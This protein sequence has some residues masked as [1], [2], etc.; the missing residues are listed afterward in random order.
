LAADMLPTWLVH[1]DASEK[2]VCNWHLC[3]I[4]IMSVSCY[5]L[6]YNFKR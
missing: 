1:C 6:T 3:C 2:Q 5:I 4:V